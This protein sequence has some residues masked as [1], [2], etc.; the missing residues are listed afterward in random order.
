MIKY[1]LGGV[2]FLSFLTNYAQDSKDSML[3][4]VDNDP[5]Y[6]SEFKRVFN[7]NIDLVKDESQKD[8]DE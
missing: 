8:V 2:F 1:F 4:S 6:I 3:F 5:V 7:K